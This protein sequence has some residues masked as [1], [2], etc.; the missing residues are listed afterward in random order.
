[1]NLQRTALSIAA[2]AAL[3]AA[4]SA[5]AAPADTSKWKCELCPAEETGVSGSVDVGVGYKAREDGEFRDYNGLA[6]RRFPLSVGA[7]LRFRGADGLYGS[8]EAQDLTSDARALQAEVGQQGLF[9]ARLGYSEITRHQLDGAATPFRGVGTSTLTLPAGF[10]ALTTGAMPLG[11]TLEPVDHENKRKRLDGGLAWTFSPAFSAR[12]SARH[13]VRDGTQRTAG[14]FFS[15]AS[16]LLAPVDQ[17]IDS[18]EATADF[19]SGPFQ[20]SVSYYGSWFRNNASSLTW[21]NPFKPL[22]AGAQRGEL[23]LAPD[24]EFN[25][26]SVAGAY[27]MGPRLRITGDMAWGQMTQDAAFLSASLNPALVATLP[28]ASLAGRVNTFNGN[29]RASSQITDDLRLTATYSRDNRD[30]R[31]RS[32]AWPAVVTDLEVESAARVNQPFSFTR[33]LFKAAAEYRGPGSI[34]A[35]AGF[36]Y[37]RRDRTRQEVATTQEVTGWMR[38]AARPASGLSVSLK[39]LHAQREPDDYGSVSWIS[40]AEN[41]LMRKFN[42]AARMRDAVQAQADTAVGDNV[43]L[44]FSVDYAWDRYNKSSIGLTSAESITLGGDISVA[45][46]DDTRVHAYLSAD[47]IDS[48]QAGAETT[49]TG[50]WTARGLDETQVAGLGVRHTALK[51]KLEIGADLTVS[52][53]WSDMRVVA[54]SA[55][56]FPTARSAFDGLKLTAAWKLQDN[57]SVVGSYW[58]EFQRSTDWHTDGVTPSNVPGLLA[59]GDQASRYRINLLRVALRYRF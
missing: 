12:V 44:S 19:R 36:D 58:Y 13:D 59:L 35:T 7:G 41:P 53:S 6:R 54:G 42:M 18:L 32:L 46:T 31:T 11:T 5:Q 15:T 10:P 9:R 1:M 40:P 51:G 22:V 17:T 45:L 30:N 37:D 4:T 25:Q 23:A 49:T 38:F 3:C 33:D 24:N 28:A 56:G 47:R 27:D 14:S 16:Q 29:A 52:R 50:W 55:S 39:V 48:R 2:I 26:L 21:A 8:L 43:N 34:R 20:A 57:V